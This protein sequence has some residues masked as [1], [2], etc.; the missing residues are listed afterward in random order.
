[1]IEVQEITLLSQKVLEI[2]L[3]NKLERDGRI[4][5]QSSLS[6]EVSPGGE[7]DRFVG[8]LEQSMWDMDTGGNR[9]QFTIRVAG[10]FA[11]GRKTGG[12]E[13]ER[14][15]YA[16]I[17]DRMFPFLQAHCSAVFVSTGLPTLVL[18][19]QDVDACSGGIGMARIDR[20][21]RGGPRLNLLS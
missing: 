18:K 9:F 13:Q 14:N 6:V 21:S 4:R 7:A 8:I 19:M 12:E 17:Y 11:S 5:L 1:M 10:I 16:E 20:D 2:R 3:E 15:L